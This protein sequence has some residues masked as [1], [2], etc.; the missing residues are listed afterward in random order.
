MALT[1][2]NT[3]AA[4]VGRP[5]QTEDRMKTRK[6]KV[7]RPFYFERKVRERNCVIEV[8]ALFAIEVIAANKA[9]AVEESAP[10]PEQTPGEKKK[11][12][13]DAGK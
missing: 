2:E 11:E 9:E 8:P 1:V 10:A 5:L 6:V 3:G 7:V 4:L 12:V 13:K